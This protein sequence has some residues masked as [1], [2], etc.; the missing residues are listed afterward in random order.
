MHSD[1]IED[2]IIHELELAHA[3]KCVDVTVIPRNLPLSEVMLAVC[4]QT[5][6]IEFQTT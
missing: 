3:K 6:R 4:Q 2:L 5:V 1:H